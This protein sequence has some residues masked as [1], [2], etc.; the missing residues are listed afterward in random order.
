[1][2]IYDFVSC[3]SYDCPSSP[4][5]H[6]L[7]FNVALFYFIFC[8]FAFNSVQHRVRVQPID[9]QCQAEMKRWETFHATS[10]KYLINGK[11]VS[12]CAEKK[13]NNNKITGERKKPVKVGKNRRT[14]LESHFYL[15]EIDFLFVFDIFSNLNPFFIVPTIKQHHHY[16]FTRFS[17]ISKS[18]DRLWWDRFEGM[19]ESR[20][21]N[22]KNPS[23]KLQLKMK[24]DFTSHLHPLSHHSSHQQSRNYVETK[25]RK[26]GEIEEFEK[27]MERRVKQNV[28]ESI[29]QILKLKS[30]EIKMKNEKGK[31]FS[32]LLSLD[33]RFTSIVFK[34]IEL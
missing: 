13:N 7:V 34:K 27:V 29:E 8:H 21:K 19:N 10:H 31:Q 33:C 28:V 15:S 16:H 2:A 14:S 4:S 24:N 1:M 25:K 17:F 26:T 20:E 30:R 5:A 32:I 23:R 11:R 18:D 6:S 9:Q 12:V 3:S 22:E